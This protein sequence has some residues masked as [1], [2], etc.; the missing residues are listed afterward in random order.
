M[1]TEMGSV[2]LKSNGKYSVSFRTLRG[3]PGD[4]YVACE[5]ESAPVFETEDE[6]IAGG[7]RALLKLSLTGRFPDMCEKF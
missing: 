5:S 3:Q 1:R 7:T 2:T 4:E 6:A